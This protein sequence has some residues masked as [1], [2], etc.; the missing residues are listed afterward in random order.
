MNTKYLTLL[1]SMAL[2][3]VPTAKIFGQAYCA[4]R[5]PVRQVYALFPTATSFRSVVKVVDENARTKVR[6]NSPIDLHF[7]ELGKHTL[8]VVYEKEL[9]LGFIHVRSELS[10]WGLAEIAWALSPDLKILDYSFQRCRSIYR[11]ALES[12]PI[13]QELRNKGFPELKNY[14]SKN[15][16]E[17]PTTLHGLPK[18]S[19]KLGQTVIQCALKTTL[20]TE[21]VWHSE[22]QTALLKAKAFSTF[23]SA[24]SI[25]KRNAAYSP[26]LSKKL[27]RLLQSKSSLVWREKNQAFLINNNQKKILGIIVYTHLKTQP[28]P[29]ELWWLIDSK[30]NVIDIIPKFHWVS[31]NTKES[32]KNLIHTPIKKDCATASELIRLEVLSLSDQLLSEMQVGPQK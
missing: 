6:E 3:L 20:L 10:E 5:D 27:E 26:E 21:I 9:P 15:K 2:V 22:V 4:L 8:Y 30:N 11:K 17:S 23:P 29:L 24:K 32:F 1:F 25:T 14:V 16:S 28:N 13:K 12:D 31:V 18:G 19:K 7:N